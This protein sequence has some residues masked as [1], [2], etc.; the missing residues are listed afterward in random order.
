MLVDGPTP[1]AG[2]SQGGARECHSD[3]FRSIHVRW[4]VGMFLNTSRDG[5]SLMGLRQ[6]LM[7]STSRK[8][9]KHAVALPMGVF[10]NL[11]S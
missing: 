5:L 10:Y 9:T 1:F 11:S 6:R 4:G 7:A 3:W 2:Q 8:A